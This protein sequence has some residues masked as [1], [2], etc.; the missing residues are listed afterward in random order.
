[1]T[2]TDAGGC[3]R[4]S[5]KLIMTVVRRS[6]GERIVA[7]TKA[8][9]ARGG[10]V[11]PARG[12]SEGRIE[13]L[14]ELDDAPEDVI[15][16][17]ASDD[18]APSIMD[19]LREYEDRT[20]RRRH[21]FVVQVDVPLVLKQ[22][23]GSFSGGAPRG[24]DGMRS[25]H[26]DAVVCVIVNRGC[27]DDIMAAAR[28]EG[29]G[30]GVILNGRGTARAKD[31]EFLGIPLFPEKEVLFILARRE[32]VDSLMDALGRNPCLSRPG[33]GIAFAVP[34]E[35]LITLGKIPG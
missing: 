12:K 6:R 18:E 7:L 2:S 31:V 13:R 8:A 9:G 27:A 33:G 15:F 24:S 5:G 19:A 29:A 3:R 20:G 11:I 34:A 35:N 22:G 23:A 25:H 32:R 21:G 30:P 16:T 10:T 1:M 26:K 14:L 4:S 28:E 17:L